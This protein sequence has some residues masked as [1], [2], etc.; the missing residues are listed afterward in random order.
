MRND[1]QWADAIAK[2]DAFYKA[3]PPVEIVYDPALTQGK[4]DYRTETVDVSFRCGVFP[5]YE[6]LKP[7]EM[8][9]DGLRN[10]ERND[11]WNL[12]IR[13]R[14]YLV[15][16][17]SAVFT[18]VN[19]EGKTLGTLPLTRVFNKPLPDIRDLSFRGA[20]DL[21]DVM[22]IS[23]SAPPGSKVFTEDIARFDATGGRYT[24][25][26]HLAGELT[27]SPP[28]PFNLMNFV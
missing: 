22:S 16:P 10:T 28:P 9:I 19:S 24:V 12:D 14:R 17:E 1:I 25:R 18:L 2:A 23:V 6:A 20:N 26:A 15:S 7:L 11:D 5:D 27:A 8:L 21:T 4:I 3:D 13:P